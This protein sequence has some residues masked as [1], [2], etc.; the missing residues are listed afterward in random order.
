MLGEANTTH[1][2]PKA[3]T[4]E[5]KGDIY[6]NQ[7]WQSTTLRGPRQADRS[8]LSGLWPALIPSVCLFGTAPTN[9]LRCRRWGG[10]SQHWNVSHWN[11]SDSEPGITGSQ[12]LGPAFGVVPRGL[13]PICYLLNLSFPADLISEKWMYLLWFK[14]QPQAVQCEETTFRKSG[15]LHSTINLIFHQLCGLWPVILFF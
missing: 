8:R 1:S 2:P 10:G 14:V 6:I 7:S 13:F 12:S 5:W 15:G 4:G 11:G 9:T 3:G